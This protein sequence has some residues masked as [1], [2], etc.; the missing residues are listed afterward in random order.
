MILGACMLY[1]FFV[2]IHILSKTF[3][4]ANLIGH[5]LK[6]SIEYMGVPRRGLQREFEPPK[7]IKPM[8]LFQ[9]LHVS[10]SLS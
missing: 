5:V 9:S 1:S 3:L 8:P 7:R 2:I 4:A 6:N 10:Q